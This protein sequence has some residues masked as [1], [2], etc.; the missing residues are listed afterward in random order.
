M[1][2]K[3]ISDSNCVL[4]KILNEEQ[5]LDIVQDFIESIIDVKIKEISIQKNLKNEEIFEEYL[6]IINVKII[7]DINE[8]I[9]VGIQIIDG[10]YIQHK[11]ILY[12]AQLQSNQNIYKNAVKTITINIIDDEFFEAK[13][14]CKISRIK[15]FDPAV[16]KSTNLG[17]LHIIELPKF[18]VQEINNKEEAWVQY[19][20]NGKIC[21]QYEK[22][23]KLDNVLNQYWENEII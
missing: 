8:V 23:K 15:G 10:Y 9:N 11:M 6:G 21:K 1:N 18:K 17:E 4:K 20:K 13:N 14:Y 5:N 19:L 7:T 16:L 2:R 12:Y 3:F 22:I